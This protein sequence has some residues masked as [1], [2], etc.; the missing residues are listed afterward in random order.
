[1]PY[2]RYE[3]YIESSVKKNCIN[4]M[5]FLS[6]ICFITN[7]KANV[8]Q[9]KIFMKGGRGALVTFGHRGRQNQQKK[10][11]SFI[12]APIKVRK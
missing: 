5:A 2:Y 12:A 11:K 8:S 7:T 4:N 3:S 6:L 9:I 1:M 10:L